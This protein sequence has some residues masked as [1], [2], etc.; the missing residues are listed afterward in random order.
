[1]A[2]VPDSWVTSLFARMQ[3]LWG[4][5]FLAMW[6][7]C[8][9]DAVKAT[10]AEGLAKVPVE[11]L[12]QG[13]SALFHEKG[14]PDLPRFLTLCEPRPTMHTPHP[15]LV[16]EA[17]RTPSADARANLAAIA[18]RIGAAQP[19]IA[20]ARRLVDEAADGRVL[21][22]NRL[23]VALDALDG[24]ETT[25]GTAKAQE[26]ELFMPARVPSPHIYRE[27]GCDDE[28]GTAQ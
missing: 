1:M 17:N 22:G 6:A 8:D 13:V 16:D 12:K 25:H 27:P 26:P 2:R 24:W 4:Q 18:K 3:S 11:R 15:S 19:G 5:R 20:W 28:E 9:L 21:P 23:Q 7:D 14:P 10:W